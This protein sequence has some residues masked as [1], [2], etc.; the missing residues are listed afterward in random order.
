MSKYPLEQVLRVKRDRVEKAE[1]FVEE[2]KRALAIEEEK[3]QKVTAERDAV[4]QHHDAKL[5]QLRQALDEGTT[6]D[7]VLQMKAYL[8][9]VKEKLAK[10]E[11]KVEKQKEQV[12]A[13]EK[14]LEAAKEELKKKRMEEEKIKVHRE[15]WEKEMKREEAI[16]EAKDQDELGQLMHES[17]RRKKR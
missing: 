13:A 15:E 10:E 5:A 1:K 7:E 4:K 11:E 17:Q 12:K 16:Q 8:K 9:V 3:L 14:A 6:S 2:K